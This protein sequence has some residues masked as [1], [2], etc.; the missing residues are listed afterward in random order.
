MKALLIYGDGALLT[1]E[2]PSDTFH[3]T[4]RF[5]A[6]LPLGKR[7][8]DRDWTADIPFRVRTFNWRCDTRAYHIYE[9]Q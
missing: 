5:P 8:E 9:E 2:L 1:Y 6:R 7:E 3:P 4:I